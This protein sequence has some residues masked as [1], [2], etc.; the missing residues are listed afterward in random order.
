ML[1]LGAG[2]LGAT[3]GPIGQAWG[4]RIEAKISGGGPHSDEL[5]RGW[6]T[7]KRVRSAWRSSRSGWISRSACCRS[8][9]RPSTA[10][11]GGRMS[12]DGSIQVPR[13]CHRAGPG[14]HRR[15]RHDGHDDRRRLCHAG[16]HRARCHRRRDLQG[17]R[18]QGAGPSARER[19]A[20]RSPRRNS[21]RTW[22]SCRDGC[23]SWKKARLRR[24][25]AQRRRASPSGSTG[26]A[27]AGRKA[28][29]DLSQARVVPTTGRQWDM[30]TREDVQNWL[31][32][33]DGGTLE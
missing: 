10:G 29:L 1:A 18:R 27:E 30:V 15:R 16:A 28:R 9:A 26:T 14:G 8:S 11:G 19:C 4:R 24:A 33:L 12:Q 23:W 20:A 31:D 3:L 6:P 32:R 17:R 2:L 5:A 22:T 7:W 21:W 25:H 13:R